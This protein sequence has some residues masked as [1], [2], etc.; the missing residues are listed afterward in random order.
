MPAAPHILRYD[1]KLTA[2][3]TALPS[4]LPSLQI[5][6]IAVSLAHI[7]WWHR[8]PYERAREGAVLHGVWVRYS[9]DC[10][11][12]LVIHHCPFL[13]VHSTCTSCD[14]DQSFWVSTLVYCWEQ[15]TGFSDLGML[16]TPLPDPTRLLSPRVC[17]PG[18]TSSW[19]RSQD[20]HPG[21]SSWNC[22]P[23]IRSTVRHTPRPLDPPHGVPTSFILEFNPQPCLAR[24]VYTSPHRLTE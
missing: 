19:D 6:Y 3:N 24:S 11:C 2:Y 23:P 4:K 9:T 20:C 14:E 10:A 21:L 5:V 13:N 18:G 1:C 22:H 16:V 7:A 12:L 17:Q 15:M 8:A